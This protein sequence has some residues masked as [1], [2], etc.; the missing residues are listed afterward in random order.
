M[1]ALKVGEDELS[2]GKRS[3][4]VLKLTNLFF[5]GSMG[6]VCAVL[7]CVLDSTALLQY[8]HTD[9]LTDA[10]TKSTSDTKTMNTDTG[11]DTHT[12]TLRLRPAHTST[13]A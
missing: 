12:I 3:N 11:I 5:E 4:R 7:C 9:T 13:I 2:L 1:F 8:C 6:S 10:Q